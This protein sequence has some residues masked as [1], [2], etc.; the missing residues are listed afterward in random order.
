MRNPFKSKRAILPKPA[1]GVQDYLV[2]IHVILREPLPVLDEPELPPVVG[3]YQNFGMRANPLA[4]RDLIISLVNDGEIDWSEWNA[5]DV[6][7]LDPTIRRMV[8]PITGDGVWYR[9][10]RMFHPDPDLECVPN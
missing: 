5:T 4:V 9:S 3:Y 2:M 10:G 1:A 7:R 8:Q 6:T